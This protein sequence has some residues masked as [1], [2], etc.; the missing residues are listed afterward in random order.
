MT[1]KAD[2]SAPTSGQRWL[3]RGV[4]GIGLASLC[5]DWGHE[6]GTALLPILLASFGAPAYAL[7][8]IEGV[9]DGFSSFAKLAGGWIA[10]RPALRKPVAVTGYLLTGLSTFAF[11]FVGSWPQVLASHAIGWVGRGARGPARD[12]L[13]TDAVAPEQVGRAFGFER[14][15]DTVGAILGPLCATALVALT[16]VRV[17]MRWTLFPGALAA[18]AFAT[19][20]PSSKHLGEHHPLPFTTSLKRLP[21]EFRRFLGAVGL[22]GLGDF[23]HTLLI[24]RAVQMLTSG[25]GIVRAGGIAVALY[26]FH[27]V[28]Y[29]AASYPAGT[30]GDKIGRR[31][32]L[33]VGYLL[34][35]AMSVGF[36]LAPP[37][38][39]ELIG[40]FGLAGLYVAIQD[41][42]EKS[43]AAQLL[44]KEI[45]ATGYG[46]LATVNG[47][48]DFASSIAVGF[49]WTIISPAAGFA[50]AAILTAAGGVLLF[51][52]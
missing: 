2:N 7:G 1:S 42:L 25:Y 14:T 35:A 47:L 36:I 38:L 31:G 22:F 24:L 9:A 20:V 21:R 37:R 3:T 23:A 52:A 34:A 48:G 13:L 45:R 10:D 49:L 12:V 46:V 32:V 16:S 43:V 44:P 30:L 17:A 5:S 19:L 51:F 39:P 4:F 40:L 41:T 18:L 27:N 29:A 6:I 26:T 28:I 15:M 33:I 11:G 50:Y 8:V